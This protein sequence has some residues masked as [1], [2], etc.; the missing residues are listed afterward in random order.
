MTP[1]PRALLERLAGAF[2]E[3]RLTKIWDVA[4]TSF[5]VLPGL[6][7]L[8]AVVLSGVIHRLDG[9]PFLESLV[10]A[11]WLYGGGPAGAREILAT[12][13]GSMIT[14]AGVVFSITVVALTLA[15]NQFG[16]RLLRAFMDDRGNQV[17]LGTFTATFLFCILG[18]RVVDATRQQPFVPHLTVTV[19]VVLAVA[20]IGVLI[21]F[22]H[23]VAAAIQAPRVVERVGR[24]L[25]RAVAHVVEA[26]ARE[27]DLRGETGPPSSPDTLLPEGFAETAR[28]VVCHDVGYVQ[29]VDAARLVELGR[30]R[31]LVLRLLKDAG[32]YVVEGSAVALA[33][34]RE[35]VDDA[36]EAAIRKAFVT[37]RRRTPVQDVKHA[38]EQ[39]TELAVRALSPGVNDPFTAR[40]CVWRSAAALSRVME[41]GEP[42]PMRTDRQGHVRLVRP[43]LR[44]GDLIERAWDPVRRHARGS[45][46]VLETVLDAVGELLPQARSEDQRRAL[47]RQVELVVAHARREV[48]GE[49]EREGV[50]AK[51]RALLARRPRRPGS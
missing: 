3:A 50:E 1:R 19:G 36:T 7:M 20:S 27:A 30:T 32:D 38:F 18:L 8:L 22:I 4:R 14:I 37:G 25:D 33:W 45:V 17:V 15:S 16:P 12:I 23:H 43:P 5:W 13:A 2:S 44:F 41:S 26:P 39:L 35:G 10:D 24:E 40:T 49:R 51:A 46:I 28:P 21:Y 29:A 48:E 6:M 47:R 9:S 34:P 42:P 11:G 31:G